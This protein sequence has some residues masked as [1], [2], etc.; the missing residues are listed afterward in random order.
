MANTKSSKKDMRRTAKKTIRN[1]AVKSSLKTYVKK[2]RTAA[3]ANDTEATGVAV[4]EVVSAMDKAVQRGIIHKNQAARRKSRIAKAANAVLKAGGTPVAVKA[5][6]NK[7]EK[8]AKPEA[9][10]VAKAA[11]VKTAPEKKSETV[12]KPV[13]AS[14]KATAAEAKP[15]AK[16]AAASKKKA[17]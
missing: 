6:R 13:A 17:D 12:K 5:A 15:A 16:K 8:D 2:V 10:P 1:R 11:A 4:A 14:K 3:G 7:V 9:K